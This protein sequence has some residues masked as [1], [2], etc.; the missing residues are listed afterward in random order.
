MFA[1]YL[2]RAAL[3]VVGLIL[4]KAP[5]IWADDDPFGNVAPRPAP[6]PAPAAATR[7]APRAAR[8]ATKV[9]S[10][11]AKKRVALPP[12]PALYR[13][14]PQRSSTE[15]DIEAALKEPTIIEFVET[16]L[17]DVVEYLKD[18]HKVEI[19]LDVAGL[20]EAGVEDEAPTTKNIRGVPLNCSLTMIL[21]DIGL[22]W[23]VRNDIL[24]IT[25]HGRLVEHRT[26]KLYEVGDLIATHDASGQSK[27]DYDSLVKVITAT[28]AP[29]SWTAKSAPASIKGATL[30]GA[31]VLSVSA[32]YAVHREVAEYL[33]N[34]RRIAK[35]D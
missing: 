30:G 23:E 25:N 6:K 29:D 14:W 5:A 31:K 8:P 3:L 27:D 33:A 15:N 28:V 2:L 21:D 11:P 13:Y 26:T 9:P 32:P 4:V 18:T 20:K 7:P 35:H 1:A 34:V 12:D 24:L 22:G 17:K 19:Q 10:P 16:P